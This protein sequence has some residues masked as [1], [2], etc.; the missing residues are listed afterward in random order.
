MTVTRPRR[1]SGLSAAVSVVRSMDEQATATE[2]MLGGSGR[3]SAIII[4]YCPLVRPSGRQRVVEPPR[5]RPCRAL[6]VK[7]QAGVPNEK[8]GL[9]RS[10]AAFDM[11]QLC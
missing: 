10:S 11:P 5:E 7:T 8:R 9:E 4:E 2:P 6:Q 1:C 3:L